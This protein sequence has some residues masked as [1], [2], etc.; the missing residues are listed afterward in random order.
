MIFGVHGN[1]DE[2]LVNYFWT[3]C[4]LGSGKTSTLTS[5]M[6]SRLFQLCLLSLGLNSVPHD[7]GSGKVGVKECYCCLQ[8]VG[9]PAAQNWAHQARWDV[10]AGRGCT[11]TTG[12]SAMQRQEAQWCSQNQYRLS[13]HH[14]QRMTTLQTQCLSVGLGFVPTLRLSREVPN[15]KFS[16]L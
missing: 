11:L 16:W 4:V 9:Y 12:L 8:K 5:L 10:C 6:F 2:K 14:L 3:A 15:G 1:V 7:F 13:Q